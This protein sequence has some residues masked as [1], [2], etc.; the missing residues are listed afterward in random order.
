MQIFNSF[1]DVYTANGGGDAL[2][3]MGAFNKQVTVDNVR[4][5]LKDRELKLEQMADD[6]PYKPRL[7]RIHVIDQG[8]AQIARVS[9]QTE[10]NNPPSYPLP[11]IDRIMRDSDFEMDVRE[12]A[13]Q[14]QEES[15]SLRKELNIVAKPE[16]PILIALLKD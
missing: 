8:V 1:Q 12:L 2:S 16:S 6:H 11:Q 13:E 7:E 4:F 5:F 14:F 10:K 15:A 3:G 9:Y